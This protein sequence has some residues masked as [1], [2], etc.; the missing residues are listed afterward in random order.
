LI[1]PVYQATAILIINFQTSP[2]S[3]DS[4]S[5]SLQVVPTYAQLLQSPAVLGPVLARHPGMTLKNLTDMITVTTKP[6]SQ[7]IELDVD[8]TNPTLAMNIANEISNQFVQ[9]VNPQLAA[10]VLPVYATRPT[11]PVRPRPLQDA[12]IGALVGLGLALALIFLFEWIDDRL[13]SPEEVQ[14]LLGMETLT[15][16]PRLSRR[17]LIKKAE[18]VPALAEACRMLCAS[19]NAAQALR[20]FKLVMVTSA[21]AG[22]GKS[23]VAAN[24]ASFLA[25]AGKRVLLVDADLRRPVQ[26]RHFQLDNSRGLSHVLVPASA[27]PGVEPQSQATDIPTLRVL[28]AGVPSSHSA[29]LLQSPLV[30]QLFDYFIKAPFD[31]ILFDTPPLLPVA[32]AQAL[33]SHI[34]VTVVVVDAS[35]TPRKILLRVKSVFNRTDTAILGVA[36]NKCRWPEYGYIREYQKQ[37]GRSKATSFPDPSPAIAATHSTISSTS[38]ES[39]AD[40]PTSVFPVPPPGS[41]TGKDEKLKPPIAE[42][43][44][45]GGVD[46]STTIVLPRPKRVWQKSRDEE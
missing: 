17:E 23:T 7:L 13:A 21:L 37:V 31:Y 5:A 38:P 10:S 33:A 28:T 42:A 18:E 39:V 29:E 32:D 25:L 30:D 14:D 15:I 35:K 24:L 46:Q 6:N 8:N 1:P 4:V 12:G 36:I 27:R 9:Y 45:A 26:S 3:Y 34:H 22:E 2:S 16:I 41:L 19:L 44:E 11:S 20:P 40:M 43:L